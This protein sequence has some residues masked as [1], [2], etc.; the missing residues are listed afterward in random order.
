MEDAMTKAQLLDNLQ[1]G[2]AQWEALLAQV[3][4]DRMTTPGVEGDWS[5]KDVIAH[6]TAYEQ[7]TAE[8]LEA[9]AQDTEPPA[10]PW[11][12]GLEMDARNAWLYEAHR[13]Q[14]LAAVQ[15]ESRQA[16]DRL[17]AA[18]A[19]VPDD[20]LLEPGRYVWLEGAPLW[21]IIPGNSYAHYEEEH[22]PPLRAW[23]AQ[24]PA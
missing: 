5:V 2:R 9:I 10:A 13:N 24:H 14:P 19:A 23:L 18:V 4:E 3:G 1:T 16:F 7:R 22:T 8:R 12:A 6:I 21:E 20:A 11:P 17:V 15:A